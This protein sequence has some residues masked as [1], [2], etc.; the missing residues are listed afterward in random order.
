MND[1]KNMSFEDKL[2]KVF[3][4]MIVCKNVQRIKQLSVRNIPG[5]MR[6][7]IVMRFSDEN[8]NIDEDSIAAFIKKNLPDKQQWNSYLVDMLHNNKEV[9]F[10]T[11][12]RIDFDTKSKKA[13]FKLPAFNVPA[14]R[15]EAV[16]EWDVIE[17]NREYL[18]TP[19]NVWGIVKLRCQDINGKDSILKLIGFTPFSPYKIDLSYY[20]EARKHYTLQEWVDVLIGAVDYFPDGYESFDEKLQMLKRLL[21]FVEPRLNMIELA[22]KETG[23]SY[24]FSQISKYGWLISG[25]SMTRAKLFYDINKRTNGLISRYD[26]IAFD[27]VSSIQFSDPLEIGG[28]LKGYME[29]GNYYVGDYHGVGNAGIVLLGNI[30]TGSM[31]IETNMM[32]SIPKVFRDPALMDRFHGFIEGWKI[33]KMHEELKAKGFAL[34][35]EYF[36]EILHLLREEIVYRDIVDSILVIPG[37][38]GAR[39]TEAVKRL[40]TAYLKLLFPNVRS[41]NDLEIDDFECYCLKPA[42]HMRGII[43]KQLSIIDPEEFKAVG[44]PDIHVRREEF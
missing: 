23:K 41:V 35:V 32:E 43:K 27:E 2:K 21:P 9:K 13:L 28:A 7:W 22:P 4:D 10:L 42:L 44:L 33:P 14:H 20:I 26:F 6:D 34:N 30:P 8:G 24:V 12:I 3:G 36:S 5:F 40:S 19:T 11:Q 29:S 37:D 17:R 15:E 39:D 1:C 38:A 31:N 18:L 25:G 16:A